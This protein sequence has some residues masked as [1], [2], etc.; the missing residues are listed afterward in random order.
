MVE[1]EGF[2]FGG[3]G[4][5]VGGAA[6]RGGFAGAGRV[7]EGFGVLGGDLLLRLLYLFAAHR[8]GGREW[9]GE[10]PAEQAPH[11]QDY[12]GH[13]P[14]LSEQAHISRAS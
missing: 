10:V 9:A 3:L 6:G 12:Q 13:V 8:A 5:G 2:G 14:V 11:G 7:S 1:V 4:G